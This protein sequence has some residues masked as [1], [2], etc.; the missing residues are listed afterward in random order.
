MALKLQGT[1]SAAAPGL[2]N[3]GNDGIAVGTDSIDLSIAGA[4]KFKV[5]SAGQLGIG[6]ANYGTS[7]QV[8]KSGGASAAPTW[9]TD[10][11]GE[12]VKI[13]EG[14]QTTAIASISSDA[15]DM[16]VYTAFNLIGTMLPATDQAH[17]WFRWR[18]S[19]A[20]LDVAT[21]DYGQM[22]TYP[23]DQYYSESDDDKNYMELMQNAGNSTREGFRLNLWMY[24]LGSSG[25]MGNW[26]TWAGCRLDQDNKI[27]TVQGT[28]IYD[29]D[30]QCSGFTLYPGTGD[31]SE[32][33]YTLYGVKK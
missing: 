5:G 1:N 17:L 7:G 2:T 23:N 9:G 33:D 27:R 24:P 32:I 6:G 11:G 16:S 19:N 10:T 8:L 25:T 4:S 12:V 31:W 28:G 22:Y 26:C 14:Q 13:Q 20:D 15:L 29:A 30:T 3:D 21:Y 18:A